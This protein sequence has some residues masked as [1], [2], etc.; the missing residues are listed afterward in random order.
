MTTLPRGG[1]PQGTGSETGERSGL[2]VEL[3]LSHFMRPL[4]I[5][6]GGRRVRFHKPGPCGCGR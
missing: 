2:A 5:T 6:I 3:F 1:S 4:R